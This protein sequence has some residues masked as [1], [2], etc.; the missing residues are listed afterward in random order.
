MSAVTF[1]FFAM[2]INFIL[3]VMTLFLIPAMVFGKKSLACAVRESFSLA[4]KSWADILSCLLVF[5]LVLL[6][7]S[8]ASLIFQIGYHLVSYGSVFYVFFWYQG[9]WIA[10]AALYILMWS[11]VALI[12]STLVGISLVGLYNCAKTGTLPAFLAPDRSDPA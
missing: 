11:I 12:V 10:G 3:F 7:I 4:K 5:G 6:A 8:F 9:G 2:I 1:T